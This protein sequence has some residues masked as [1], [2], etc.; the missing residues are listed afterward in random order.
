MVISNNAWL[1]YILLYIFLP[2]QAIKLYYINIGY[3][4][5]YSMS[6]QI[7]N[8]N[9]TNKFKQLNKFTLRISVSWS[10]IFKWKFK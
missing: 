5:E 3:Y 9:A 4:K 8:R 10:T 2:S 6:K 7:T 1:K